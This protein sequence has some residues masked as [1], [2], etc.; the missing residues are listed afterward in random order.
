[1]A[2]KKVKPLYY[3]KKGDSYET[4]FAKNEECIGDVLTWEYNETWDRIVSF[5]IVAQPSEELIQEGGEHIETEQP[6]AL[7]NPLDETLQ[8]VFPLFIQK[9]F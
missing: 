8:N 6:T 1:M 5:E 3:I 7:L 9:D 4:V 2:E